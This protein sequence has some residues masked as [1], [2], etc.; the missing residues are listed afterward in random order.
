V[1][2]GLVAAPVAL[3]VEGPPPATLTAGNLA[4][5]AYLAIVGAALAYALWF[6]G[7][8]ALSAT[9]VTFLALLSPIVAT[10]LGW[11]VL[12]QRLTPSQALGVVIVLGSVTVAQFRPG[13]AGAPARQD[14]DAEGVSGLGRR[15]TEVVSTGARRPALPAPTTRRP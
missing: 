11:I 4:G 12:G 13:L 14:T 10:A 9:N 15:A 1:A 2:G 5:Y 3:A 7:V 6:R 8:R